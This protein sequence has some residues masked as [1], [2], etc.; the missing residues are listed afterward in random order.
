MR[1]SPTRSQGLLRKEVVFSDAQLLSGEDAYRFG[2]ILVRDA[3]YRGPAEGDALPTC[4]SASRRSSTTRRGTASAEYE[5]IIGYHLEQAF[6]FRM[7]LG[8][9]NDESLCD[10]AHRALRRLDSAGERAL[11]RGDLPAALNLFQR[12]AALAEGSRGSRGAADRM[13]AASCPARTARGGGGAARAGARHAREDEDER[14]AAHAEI[15]L[16][17]VLLQTEPAERTAR[18]ST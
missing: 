16:E 6:G 4:T 18:S 3:A 12:A 5:E 14:W 15:G 7:E 17:F 2:H 9:L 13:S 1:R 11:Y 10:F 8:P